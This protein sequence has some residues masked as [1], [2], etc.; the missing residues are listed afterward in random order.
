MARAVWGPA[1]ECRVW[2]T[3]GTVISVHRAYNEV[4][5]VRLLS[6]CYCLVTFRLSFDCLICFCVI[7][8]GNSECLGVVLRQYTVF[9]VLAL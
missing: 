5:N 7:I 6:R 2:D 3:P 1:A 9:L 4:L 8:S